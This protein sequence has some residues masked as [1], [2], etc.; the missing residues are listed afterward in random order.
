MKTKVQ[1]NDLPSYSK[2]P[3]RL[4]GIED[5][6]Q[7]NRTRNEVL[8]EYDVEKWGGVLEKLNA[9]TKITQVDI[10]RHQGI[11]PEEDILF[12]SE[13][14]YFTASAIEVMS[15]YN[16]LLIQSIA[17]YRCD[18]IAELGCGLGDKLV[19]ISKIL[20]PSISCGGEFTESGVSCAR[21]I[22]KQQGVLSKFH[23][24]DY[25]QPDTLSW[26]PENA[27]VYTSHS[28]EQIPQLPNSFIEGLIDRKPRFVIHFEPCYEDQNPGTLIGLMRQKYITLND[29]NT[30]LITL[31]DSFEK[32]EKLKI[33]KHQR[34]I[35]SD[36]PFNPTSVIIWQ[37]K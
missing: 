8:R 34:N 7:R 27:L 25:Y 32:Q 15:F 2:W 16:D 18:A 22:A 10:L 31:L 30:N 24:F 20:K 19:E 6:F 13:E 29:Y 9:H 23:H 11:D 21:L 37:P 3:A 28:I 1:F 12:M 35:F 5:F 14:E 36:T 33:I 26:V 17:P 4:L